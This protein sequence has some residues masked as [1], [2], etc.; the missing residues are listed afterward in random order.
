MNGARLGIL[1]LAA[2]LTACSSPSPVLYTIAP[3]P[4]RGNQGGLQEDLR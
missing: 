2:A 3:V 1:A 4:G